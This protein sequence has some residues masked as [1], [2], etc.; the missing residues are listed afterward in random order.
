MKTTLLLTTLFFSL[1]VFACASNL[2][3]SI[4]NLNQQALALHDRLMF[5]EVIDLYENNS[6]ISHLPPY[7]LILLCSALHELEYDVTKFIKKHNS[8]KHVEKFAKSYSDLLK[9]K[10]EKAETSFSKMHTSSGIDQYYGAIGLLETAI[11]TLNHNALKE[12][13]LKLKKNKKKQYNKLNEA[14]LYYSIIY[15]YLTGDMQNVAKLL[16]K[17]NSNVLYNDFELLLIEVE[18]QISQ[19]RLED[20]LDSINDIISRFGPLQEAILIK[21]R[22]VEIRDGI[23]N[24]KLFIDKMVNQNSNMWQLKLTQLF[25]QLELLEDDNRSDIVRDIVAL[26]NIRAHDLQSYLMISNSLLDYGY[27]IES[28]NLMNKF[29]RATDNQSKFFMSNVYMSKFHYSTNEEVRFNVS[30][31]TAKQQSPR[32]IGFLWFQYYLAVDREASLEAAKL[33]NQILSFDPYNTSALYERMI[34]NKNLNKWELVVSD[35][36]MIIESRRFVIPSIKEEIS[37][38]RDKALSHLNQN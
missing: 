22:L 17:I 7:S 24:S 25:E 13:I 1:A 15:S 5:Q 32:D 8:E 18:F 6:N 12:L 29:F 26:A 21:Y 30:F 16:A 2:K 3:Q 27:Y 35:A 9:G 37:L 36:D 20:A 33:I 28:G 19:N 38:L 31:A 23:T 10:I 4:A 14:I 11:F 34:L